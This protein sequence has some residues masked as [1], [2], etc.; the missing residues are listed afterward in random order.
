ML[1]P[2]DSLEPDTLTNIIQ[3][4]VLR[5][6]TDYGENELSLDEKVKLVLNQ[7]IE[8]EALIEYSELHD[9][10]NIISNKNSFK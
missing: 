9:S 4:I 6:G 2:Y 5:D 10:L 3:S 1:I 8:G 7:L